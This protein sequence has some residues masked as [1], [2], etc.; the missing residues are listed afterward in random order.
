[1][2][3]RVRSGLILLVLVLVLSL[4]GLVQGTD[5]FISPSGNDGDP[6]TSPSRAWRTVEKVNGT[7]LQPGDRILFEA[8]QAF[9]G[10]LSLDARDAG[11]PANPVTIGSFGDGRA[12]LRSGKQKG[13]FAHNCAGLIVKNLN[14]IGSGRTDPAGSD[15]VSFYTDLPGGVKLDYVRID[16]IEV[17]GYRRTGIAVGAGNA[18]RSGFEDVRITNAVARDNGDKGICVYG[19]WPADP[20]KRENRNVTIAHCK[21]HDNPGI[22]GQTGHTGN[23]IILS[24]VED[25]LVEYCEAWNNGELN[26]GPEGGP[27]GIWAWEAARVI[28]QFCES[29]HNKTANG[30]DGGGFDL[31]G[32]CVDCILQYNYSHDNHGAGY[33][34]YQFEGA[35]PYKNNVVRYNISENDGLA[36][37]Y[38]ALTFWSTPSSGGI[39]NTAVYNN[40]FCV[41]E[42]TTG[43]AIN[44]L[45]TGT[46]HVHGTSLV[47][48]IIVTAPG[49]KAVEIPFSSGGWTFLNNDYWTDGGRVQFGWDGKTFVGLGAWRQ[50][51]GQEKRNGAVT[52]FETDPRLTDPGKG[53]TMG[54]PEN[55]GKLAA[56]RLRPESPMI[57]AGL[58]LRSLFGTDTGLHD[59][60]GVTLPQGS[61][62]DVGA[63]ESVKSTSIQEN[64]RGPVRGWFGLDHNYPNPF[65]PRTIIP[66]RLPE[67]SGVRIAVYDDYG[68]EVA[69][70]VNACLDAG[71]YQAVWNGRNGSGVEVANGLYFCTL[72]SRER[73]STVKMTVLR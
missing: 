39:Q 13:L 68:R 49:K 16:S 41:S 50:A 11:T 14:F 65:N 29:H 72:W 12:I 3:H 54:D 33:G 61:G 17:S 4:A 62:Y 46:T 43:A 64:L 52:G 42:K 21:A 2:Q 26:G 28:I 32:G 73:F 38:G 24:G 25:A 69:E 47:N 6:G 55:P 31:D 51:S 60:Y 37:E 30:K 36:G 5:Y 57:N 63:S 10:S 8:G 53:G 9:D 70:L 48:N 22:A 18:S 19:A 59:F 15:G 44:D 35:S 66:Y 71:V 7:D 45:A 27:I 23:G 20:A 34:I 56:Y 1:M 67:R 58:D 40:T